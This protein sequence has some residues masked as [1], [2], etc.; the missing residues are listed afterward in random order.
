MAIDLFLV[1]P[2]APTNPPIKG[3]PIRDQYMRQRFPHDV[4]T[5]IRG[6]S[7]SAEQTL[8]IGSQSTGAGAGK[9]QF[10]PLVIER[11]VDQLTP[12]LLSMEA[13]GHPLDKVQ[14]YVRKGDAR[15]GQ[16]Y[17]AFEFQLVA[18][19]NISWSGAGADDLPT[20]TVALQYG[21]LTVGYHAQ[22]ADG[23]FAD[24]TKQGWDRVRNIRASGDTIA[25]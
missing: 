13:S 21:S 11:T 19:G 14:L 8:N 15:D 10:N 17:L 24:V 12:F 18:V 6:F 7:L 5:Q 9:I 2:P 20:E 1:I 16:A 25:F 4:V 23:T 3:E 22:N